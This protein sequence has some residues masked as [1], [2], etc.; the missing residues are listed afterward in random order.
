MIAKTGIEGTSVYALS[1]L[2]RDK[3]IAT[4]AAE[5]II[6]LLPDVSEEKILAQLNKPRLHLRFINRNC[7]GKFTQMANSEKYKSFMRSR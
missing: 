6:D 1:S 2:L 4:G 3:I 7:F 5:L